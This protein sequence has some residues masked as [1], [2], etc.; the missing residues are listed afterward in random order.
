MICFALGLV[1]FITSGLQN[2]DHS[3]FACCLA[4]TNLKKL[5][6][7]IV[8][9]YLKFF[10]KDQVS[11]HRLTF[12]RKCLKNDLIPDFLKFRV[13]RKVFLDQ[14]VHNF[15]MKLLRTETSGQMR[16]GKSTR[17]C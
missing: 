7:K 17:R 8:L 15:Q 10:K 12:L 1:S 13:P 5:I 11:V 2:N 3:I 9:D 4:Q 16:T 6:W 14:A